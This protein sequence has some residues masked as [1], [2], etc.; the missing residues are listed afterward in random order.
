MAPQMAQAEHLCSCTRTPDGDDTLHTEL[1]ARATGAFAA[2]RDADTRTGAQ[3]HAANDDRSH[4]ALQLDPKPGRDGED[5]PVRATGRW[6]A[7]WRSA[8]W[9]REWFVAREPFRLG[10]RRRRL[11]QQSQIP[12]YEVRS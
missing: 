4:D 6:G 9:R 5:I 8:P 12:L 1:S 7:N 11:L 2:W 3:Y 10:R